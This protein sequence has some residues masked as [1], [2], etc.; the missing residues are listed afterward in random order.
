MFTGD[1]TVMDF[2]GTT[3]LKYSDENIDTTPSIYETL[4]K[5][6]CEVI[7]HVIEFTL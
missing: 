4:G 6:S 7:M 1:F 3:F 2:G 5:R